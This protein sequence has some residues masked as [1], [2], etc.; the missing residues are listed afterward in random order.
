MIT[1]TQEP[2]VGVRFELTREVQG[3]SFSSRL[4]GL[5]G[6]GTTMLTPYNFDGAHAWHNRR[7][8]PP[9]S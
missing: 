2:V 1:Y 7:I 4:F 9:D 6:C 5:A 3:F 8:L